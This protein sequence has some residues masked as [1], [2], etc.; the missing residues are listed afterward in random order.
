MTQTQALGFRVMDI[1][2]QA[3]YQDK[4]IVLEAMYGLNYG[5]TLTDCNAIKGKRRRVSLK[6][7]VQTF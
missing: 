5:K 7:G 1:S 2:A 3:P 6:P 4:S